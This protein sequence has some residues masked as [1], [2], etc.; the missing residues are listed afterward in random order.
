MSKVSSAPL[1][2]LQWPMPG[3]RNKRLQSFTFASP[4]LGHAHALVI[5]DSVLRRKPGIAHAVVED[6]LAAVR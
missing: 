5:V 2:P 6:Q 1:P 3:E 4:P